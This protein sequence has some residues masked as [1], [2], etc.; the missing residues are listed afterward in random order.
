MAYP[1]LATIFFASLFLL[2]IF[3][4]G[5]ALRPSLGEKHSS[6][7]KIFYTL[8]FAP[9]FI[10]IL[11]FTGPENL[12]QYPPQLGSPYKLPWAGGVERVVAQGNRSF[13]SHRD[14]H[15][16]AWDFV[17]PNGTPIEN[18][19]V[20]PHTNYKITREDF[21]NGYKDYFG[22]ATNKLLNLMP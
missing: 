17:M 4:L 14:A 13:T 19:G 8:W 15:R 16:Y 21:M 12:N 10:F 9:Y 20:T 5:S 2:A 1:L 18:N 6:K 7:I 22:A 3:I 11:F